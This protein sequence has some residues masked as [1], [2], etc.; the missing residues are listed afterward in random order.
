MLEPRFQARVVI[1]SFFPGRKKIFYLP[2][3][4]RV[5]GISTFTTSS[6]P[7]TPSANTSL[8]TSVTRATRESSVSIA[9]S[10]S[11]AL[12]HHTQHSKHTHTA[13]STRDECISI[14][15]KENLTSSQFL[16]VDN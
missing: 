2:K 13:T 6:A 3:Q 1:S 8:T 9:A 15:H 14:I 12:A 10:A 16:K 11:M 7:S 5:N 4:G